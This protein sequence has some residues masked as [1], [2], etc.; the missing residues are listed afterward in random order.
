MR[1]GETW[2]PGTDC[3][4]SKVLRK[5]R[6]GRQKQHSRLGRVARK[7]GARGVSGGRLA[8][9]RRVRLCLLL[10]GQVKRLLT[11]TA[12]FSNLE[13]ISDLGKGAAEINR[14]RVRKGAGGGKREGVPTHSAGSF[15]PREDR[16]GP[17]A[18]RESRQ[19]LKWE[20]ERV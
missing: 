14:R 11:R 9:S 5:R 13:G 10:R 8:G 2:S 1:H 12:G 19:D 17:V 18:C 6:E 15:A 20:G 3:V 4:F 16:N 7:I